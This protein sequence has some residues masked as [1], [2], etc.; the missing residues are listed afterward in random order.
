MILAQF[1]KRVQF[2]VDAHTSAILKGLTCEK[3]PINVTGNKT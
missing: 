3:Q 1:S 2:M